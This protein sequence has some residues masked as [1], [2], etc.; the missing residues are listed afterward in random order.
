MIIWLRS[1]CIFLDLLCFLLRQQGIEEGFHVGLSVMC[2]SSDYHL[3]H[4]DDV[5]AKS[6]RL[7][8]ISSV[9]VSGR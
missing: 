7:L 2:C 6:S 5:E 9:G 3:P 8:E 1:A 4:V